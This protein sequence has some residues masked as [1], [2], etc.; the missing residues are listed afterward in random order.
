MT[1]RM[2]LITP[3]TDK[4][5]RK[6]LA[7][8]LRGKVAAVLMAENRPYVHCTIRVAVIL[9][10]GTPWLH[11]LIMMT[12]RIFNLIGQETDQCRS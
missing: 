7:W 9:S 4:Y 6:H 2:Y 11:N 10:K 12:R 8:A 3:L 5:D 1:R